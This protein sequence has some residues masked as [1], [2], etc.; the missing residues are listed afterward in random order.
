[1]SYFRQCLTEAGRAAGLHK[2]CS[3]HVLTA[4]VKSTDPAVCC[5]KGIDKGVEM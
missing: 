4:V 5:K 3:P 2:Q 1:M